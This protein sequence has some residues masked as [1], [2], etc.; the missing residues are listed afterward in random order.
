MTTLIIEGPDLS[1]KSTAIEKISKLFKHGFLIK[2]LYK[3]TKSGDIKIY[4]QYWDMIHFVNYTRK[5]F[6]LDRFY[7]SQ[8]V[9]SILRNV[10][11]MNCSYIKEL[12]EYCANSDFIYVYITSPIDILMERFLA[13]GDEHIKAEQLDM[14]KTRYDQFYKQTRL[15]KIM[16]NTMQKDWLKNLE[17]FVNGNER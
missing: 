1:G 13:R 2:N 17:V 15:P 14:L 12:D 4:E 16:I 7:P 6:I 3:P 10:D 11:E 9:Y 8:A 5:F